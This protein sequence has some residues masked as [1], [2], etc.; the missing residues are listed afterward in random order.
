MHSKRVWCVSACDSAETLA[1]ALHENSWTLC[2]GFEF[3]GYL[4]LNDSTGED[5]VQ[6]Y[7]VVKRPPSPAAPFRQVESFTV[8]WCSVEKLTELVQRTVR[9]E[10]DPDGFFGVVTPRI[11]TGDEHR[12]RS[13][14]LC[15]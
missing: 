14:R 10:F 9:G 2:T 11:E 3:G 15:A 4:F 8:S 5:A 7:A 1:H 12:A 6:E 13:C